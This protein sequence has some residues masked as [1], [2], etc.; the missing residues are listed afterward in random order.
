MKVM[1][2]FSL[3]MIIL[4]MACGGEPEFRNNDLILETPEMAAEEMYFSESESYELL[5]RQKLTERLERIQLKDRYPEFDL[6]IQDTSLFSAQIG[7]EASLKD[8][9]LLSRQGTGDTISY[10]IELQFNTDKNTL[11]DTLMATILSREQRIGMD[12]VVTV[13]INFQKHEKTKYE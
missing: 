13:E 7:P 11:K 3:L 1:S 2:K 10:L 6:P 8:L 12:S 9:K 5:L 4:M